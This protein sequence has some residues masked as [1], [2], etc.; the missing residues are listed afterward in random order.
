M[1]TTTVEF[2]QRLVPVV[3]LDEVAQAEPLA[4]ALVAG[5]LPIAEVTLRTPA[6]LESIR[7]M[8][9]RGDLLV[10]AGT[11]VNPDQ[12][13]QAAD[14]GATFLVSPGLLEPVVARAQERGLPIYPGVVTPSEVM[15]ALSLGLTTLKFFPASQYG[16]AATLK[17]FGSPFGGVQFIPT[18]G[19]SLA[20]LA[21]YLA[22]PNV[23]AVGGSWMVSPQLLAAGD[24]D[25]IAR[26]TGEAVA[27]AGSSATN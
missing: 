13:D 17:A 6:A 10:G 14:A 24:F 4:E 8:A 5:G 18:G 27:A 23:H 11:V 20:N 21:E 2:P 1:S 16:G 9:A 7:L 25:S 3:I 12:V 26:L 19:V 22:L 15:K